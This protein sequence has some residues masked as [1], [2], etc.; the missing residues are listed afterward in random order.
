MKINKRA[1]D[2]PRIKLK[3]T[4]QAINRGMHQ[5]RTLEKKE[6]QSD[7]YVYGTPVVH[8]VQT[9]RDKLTKPKT[10]GFGHDQTFENKR[11]TQP[12]V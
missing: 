3:R 8:W 10:A 11:L 7:V 9:M 5:T 4:E 6:I 2:A 1:V 12:M